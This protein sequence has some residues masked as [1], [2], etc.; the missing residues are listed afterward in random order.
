MVKDSLVHSG[1]DREIRNWKEAGSTFILLYTK[2]KKINQVTAFLIT[3]G[4][5][6]MRRNGLRKDELT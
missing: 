6:M 5:V 2:K 1:K 4:K 3:I